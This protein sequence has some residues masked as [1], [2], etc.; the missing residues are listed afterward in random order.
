MKAIDIERKNRE[1]VMSF[2]EKTLKEK[3]GSC[4]P[5]H[6]GFAVPVGSS[7][8]DNALMYVVI[9]YPVTT[10]I[11]TRETEKRKIKYYNGQEESEKWCNMVK[12]IKEK[13]EK[14]I[15]RAKERAK[16]CN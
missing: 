1:E 3:F 6:N 16:N 9:P 14:A 15:S 12:E 13:K 7:P 8:L 5:V 4:Y 11:Q 2:L 10:A